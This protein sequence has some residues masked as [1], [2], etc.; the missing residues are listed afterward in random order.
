MGN[1]NHKANLLKTSKDE[2]SKSCN[3][4][5]LTEREISLILTHT[6]FNK[7]QILEIYSKFKTNFPN[8]TLTKIDFQSLFQ[9]LQFGRRNTRIIDYIYKGTKQQYLFIKK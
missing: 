5:E 2:V 6:S 3:E 1:I 4:H 9:K 8:G 7:Q